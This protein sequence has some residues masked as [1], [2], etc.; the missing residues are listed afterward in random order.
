MEL[1]TLNDLHTLI[2]KPN[3]PCVSMFMPT[4]RA[5]PGT[6]QDPIRFRNLLRQA[7]ERLTDLG[8]ASRER[9][10]LLA[11]MSRFLEPSQA[12]F[13]REQGDGLALFSSNDLFRCYR[14][15]LSLKELVVVGERFHVKPLLPMFTANGHYYVLALSQNDVRLYHC[16]RHT[17]STVDLKDVPRSLSEALKYDD[18]ERR[19]QFRSMPSAGG[20]AGTAL[21]HGHGPGYEDTKTDIQRYFQ[22]VERGLSSLLKKEAAPLVLAGVDYLHSIYRDVNTYPGLVNKGLMGNP[23]GL[24]GQELRDRAWEQVEPLLTK[25]MEEAAGRYRQLL[26]TGLASGDLAAIVPAAHQGRVDTLF[27]GVG[28]QQWGRFDPQ[29]RVVEVHEKAEPGDEDLLDFV[30]VHTLLNSGKVYAPAP[31]DVPGGTSAAAVFRY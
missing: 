15:P 1:L 12:D 22:Q 29:R 5:G 11:P 16:T 20:G 17:V 18:P 6:Q 10:A 31:G 23:E 28:V 24:S 26:G 3:R 2:Q 14:L 25:E 9:D 7:N 4:H 21:F 30:A 8:I 27:V 13:W 19:L